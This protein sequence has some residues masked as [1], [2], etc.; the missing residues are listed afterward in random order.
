MFKL[1][2]LNNKSIIS[3]SVLTFGNFDGFHLGHIQIIDKV[4]SLSK[5]NKYQSIFITFNPNTKKIINK[6][7]DFKTLTSFE[8]KISL[9]SKLNI[10]KICK[11]TFNDF[12]SNLSADNFIDEIIKKFNPSDIVLG[13]DNKFGKGGAGSFNYLINSE[14]YDNINFHS[15]EPYKV[16]GRIVKTSMIKSL[17]L[18]GD[19]QQ[20]KVYLGRKYSINGLVVK[21][22]GLATSLGFPTAN[23]SVLN[24]EQLI[25]KNGVYSVNLI[26]DGLIKRGICN[27]GNKPTFGLNKK[28]IE[29]HLLNENIDL[30]NKKVILEFN[31]YVRKELKF[32]NEIDLINQIKIDINKISNKEKDCVK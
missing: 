25:P 16:N 27:I 4:V 24:A 32:K 19:L 15:I 22:D 9:A 7:D 13:Y 1:I 2:N 21:G 20:V 6:I 14:K 30:Y 31:F 26:V 11:I 12:F 10:D 5:K 18:K 23:I 3:K 17:I 28:T 29:V 8:E